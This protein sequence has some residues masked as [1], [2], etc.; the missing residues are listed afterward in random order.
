MIWLLNFDTQSRSCFEQ[1]NGCLTP[2][3]GAWHA[4]IWVFFQNTAFLLLFFSACKKAT[5]MVFN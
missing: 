1:I 2:E 5:S 4:R 3:M